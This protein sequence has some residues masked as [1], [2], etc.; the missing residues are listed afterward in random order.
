MVNTASV[1][2]KTN[3]TSWN[4]RMYREGDIPALAALAAACAAVDKFDKA[5]SVEEITQ[6]YSQPL[7]EPLRQVIVID[8]PAQAGVDEGV[9]LGMARV[10]W[11]DDP[12]KGEKTY[13][14]RVR[15]HPAV[16]GTGIETALAQRL[17]DVVRG[18]A[19]ES[20]AIAPADMRLLG[21]AA[22]ED[23]ISR[24]IFGHMGLQ[25]ARY[26]WKMERSLAE[27][28][29]RPKEVEG[30]TVRNYRHPEDDEG[31][32]TA[33]NNSFIDHYE[34]HAFTPEIWTY[35][36]S[37]PNMRFDLSWLAEIKDGQEA[38]EFAGFCI[39]EIEEHDNAR[40]G[41]K[42]GWIGL[43]GTV[44]GWRGVGLG[45]SLLL[46]GL[47]SLKEA[48]METAVLGVDSESLTGANRLYESVGFTIR[49]LEALYKCTLADAQI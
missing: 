14:M 30:V 40:T 25:V 42:E 20:E 27:P 46:K 32:R 49:S 38:G 31:T 41:N 13:Q 12:E 36:A 47:H 6:S 22:Q 23:E 44:R 9:P 17:M 8:G 15:I 19:A 2:S 26:G 5:I 24:Q 10:M 18:N 35:I 16:R 33:Y 1:E 34:F 4:M 29:P 21:V 7:S 45:K 37:Q 11:L 28:I 48:G 43:L 39:C 3:M